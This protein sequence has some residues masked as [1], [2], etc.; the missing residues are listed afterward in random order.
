VARLSGAAAALRAAIGAPR[1]AT[2]RAGHERILA[3][4][5]AALSP[6]V[7]TAAWTAGEAAPV[8]RTVAEAIL[9]E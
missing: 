4:A 2:D 5:R 8:E 9:G 1:S 6:T 7:F 3:E